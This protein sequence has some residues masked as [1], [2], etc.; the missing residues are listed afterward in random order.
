MSEDGETAGKE[1][2]EPQDQDPRGNFLKQGA[3]R[4]P[5]KMEG[6]AGGA[7]HDA[8]QNPPPAAADVDHYD[9]DNSP[10]P[11]PVYPLPSV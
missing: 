4:K 5:L 6:G 7:I 11:P 8:H 2:L 9:K 3:G 1:A 10:L